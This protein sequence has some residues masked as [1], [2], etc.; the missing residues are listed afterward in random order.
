MEIW[1]DIINY[2]N[3]YQVSSMGRVRS[4]D[5]KTNTALRHNTSVIKK[6]KVLKQNPKR[7]GYLTVDL[8]LNNKKKTI[9]IH[10][11]VL[12]AFQPNENNLIINHKN[13]IKTDN[14]L[15]NLEWC[16]HKENSQHASKLGLLNNQNSKKIMC[17]ELNKEFK[18]SVEAA[19]WLNKTKYDYSK[20]TMCMARNIR[21][22]C[23]GKRNKAFGYKWQDLV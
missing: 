1:K 22:V 18:N 23:C 16:T 11:L 9:N 17:V 21:A 4:L 10:R 12:T 13:G 5:R 14:R 3:S 8:C 20:Q 19:E 15:E 7:D 6:G 2:E